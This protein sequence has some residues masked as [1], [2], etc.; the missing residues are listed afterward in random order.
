MDGLIPPTTETPANVRAAMAG[1]LFAF[2]LILTLIAYVRRDE[3]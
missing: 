3:L 2:G 1:I